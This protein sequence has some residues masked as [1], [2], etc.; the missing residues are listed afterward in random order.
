MP[1]VHL[2]EEGF[3]VDRPLADSLNDGLRSSDDFPEFRRVYGKNG[4]QEK[5]QPG[6]RLV[7]PEL[8]V[9]LKRI[10]DH[11]ADGFY[12]GATA[13]L[14]AAE[15]KA[16]G[17]LITIGDLQN[18]R[19]KLRPPIHGTFRGYHIYGPPP[20]S[21]GGIAL[22]QMLN[23]LENFDLKARRPILRRRPCT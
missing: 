18:Y 19:A 13:D 11:G 8:A 3:E 7:L 22:V 16:G 5:W 9:T 15:M 17:G 20:P 10:A 23:I 14:M 6:D 21:S 4:G 12:T 2:A 1:A